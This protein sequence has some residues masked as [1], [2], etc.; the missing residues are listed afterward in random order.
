MEAGALTDTEAVVRLLERAVADAV[1]GRMVGVF[2]RLVDEDG[3]GWLYV[4]DAPE[5]AAQPA[6]T[7]RVQ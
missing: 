3:V 7:A 2:V 6:V 4:H 5:S 1:A